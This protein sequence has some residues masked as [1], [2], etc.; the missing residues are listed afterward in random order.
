MGS[1]KIFNV[2]DYDL[3]ATL[4]SGQAFRWQELD[5][6]WI[7]VIGNH[8]A[9]LRADEFSISA[10]CAEPISN[11]NWLTQYLQL[12]LDLNEMLLKFPDDKPMRAAVTAC[13][14]LRSSSGT[15]GMPGLLHFVFDQTNRADPANHHF[16]L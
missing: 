15:V 13:R 9:R 4:A 7:G 5:G 1:S 11:W 10:T 14:G 8:W 6:G 2:R 16:A 12:D 3:A